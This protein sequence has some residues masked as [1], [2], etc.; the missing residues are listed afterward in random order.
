ML[1]GRT[2]QRRRRRQP[3]YSPNTIFLSYVDY[4]L[5]YES[6]KAHAQLQPPEFQFEPLPKQN[7]ILEGVR[8]K[9]YHYAMGPTLEQL[10]DISWK[11]VLKEKSKD[12]IHV[13]QFP[14]NGEPPR[15]RLVQ[16]CTFVSASFIS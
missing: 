8:W 7:P 9:Y 1:S 15:D 4:L 12:M 6:H 11:Y 10:P 3:R 2:I 14:Y 16:V 13:L 5:A